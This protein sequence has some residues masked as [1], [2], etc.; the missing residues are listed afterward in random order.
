MGSRKWYLYIGIV[1]GFFLSV[2][3]GKGEEEEGD[4]N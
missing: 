2:Q 3:H 1:P 4:K